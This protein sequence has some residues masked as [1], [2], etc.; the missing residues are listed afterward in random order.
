[1]KRRLLSCAVITLLAG[2]TVTLNA[3]EL[4][5][6]DTGIVELSKNEHPENHFN[7][8]F[9]NRPPNN[10]FTSYVNRGGSLRVRVE[11]LERP[12]T[13]P[14]EFTIFVND[15]KSYGHRRISHWFKVTEKKGVFESVMPFV[16]HQAWEGKRQLIDWS[17]PGDNVQI[18]YAAHFIGV[19]KLGGKP[20]IPIT[21]KRYYP[22]KIRVAV[23]LVPHSSSSLAV[24]SGLRLWLRADEGIALDEEGTVSSWASRIAYPTQVNATQPTLNARPRLIPDAVSGKPAVR[25]DGSDDFLIGR[26]DSLTAPITL[27]AV[28]RFS[29]ASQPDTDFDYIISIGSILE[30]GGHVSISRWGTKKPDDP[31]RNRFYSVYDS[32]NHVD[33]VGPV[34]PGQVYQLITVVHDEQPPRHSLYLNGEKQEVL[35]S[36]SSV[37]LN[38]NYILGKLEH[39]RVSHHLNGE[40]A[41]ILLY[42]RALS[43]DERRSA[44]AYLKVRYGIQ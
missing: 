36:P 13:A 22:M 4:M 7:W 10:D 27:F 11:I 26:L 8:A 1:M 15:H 25:F 24:T 39:P 29:R 44:E 33:L 9:T 37:R 6:L 2:M 21:D 19:P 43:H 30:A 28:A 34:L 3:E 40:I 14:Y 41:E 38:G 20:N 16:E 12:S 42:Q 32:L 5:V 35:D 31:N 17:N 18:M 23:T